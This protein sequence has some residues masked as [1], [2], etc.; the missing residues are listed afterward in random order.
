MSDHETF[1]DQP[2]HTDHDELLGDLQDALGRDDLEVPAHLLTAAREAFAWRRVDE[3][4][5]ELVAAEAPAGVRGQSD[6]YGFA[7]SDGRHV[8]I[9]LQRAG[10]Q[11]IALGQ[12]SPP[13]AAVVAWE[14]RDGLGPQ[15]DVGDEGFF[16]LDAV[17][18]GPVRIVVTPEDGTPLH[19][20]WMVV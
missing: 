6:T 8:D 5:A 2:S 16:E 19:T 15:V 14:S 13:A 11:V 12:L 9:E 20:D 17:P 1:D 4:L 7:G 18:R 10:H 3:A